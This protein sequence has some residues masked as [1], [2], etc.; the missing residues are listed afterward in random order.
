MPGIVDGF[1]R[2]FAPAPPSDTRGVAVVDPNAGKGSASKPA[3][4]LDANGMPLNPDNPGADP[5]NQG[6][7]GGTDGNKGS[8]PSSPLDPFKDLFKIDPNNQPPA[9]PF[10]QALIEMDPKKLGEAVSKL[11]FTQGINKEL[12]TKALGGDVDSMMQVL[13]NNARAV[14][15]GTAN[16]MK[17]VVE[18]AISKNNGRLDSVFGDRMRSHM[19]NFQRPNNEA[20]SH[21]AVQPVLAALRTTISQ[22]SAGRSMSPEDISKKAEEYFLSMSDAISAAKPPKDTSSGP[23]G[24]GAEV[25][26]TKFLETT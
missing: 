21:P 16:M 17:G 22:S 4:K 18:A 1:A 13:N 12:M 14:F 3:P 24:T 23:G 15:A 6:L 19:L 2:L 26:W 10:Q 8:G 5:A 25:D 9:D 20:L 7:D 11:N